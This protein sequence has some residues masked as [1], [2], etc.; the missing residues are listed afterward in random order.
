MATDNDGFITI[1]RRI[2]QWEWYTATMKRYSENP[3]VYVKITP[4]TEQKYFE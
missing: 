2:T 4:T 3:G 1:H